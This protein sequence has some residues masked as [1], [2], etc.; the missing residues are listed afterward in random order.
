MQGTFTLWS[1][2]SSLSNSHNGIYSNI[3]QNNVIILTIFKQL[4]LAADRDLNDLLFAVPEQALMLSF[5]DTGHVGF[6]A[7]DPGWSTEVHLISESKS[8]GAV[9]YDRRDRVCINLN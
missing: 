8:P 4:T 5:E 7:I 3:I 2:I 1:I 9:T 6:M